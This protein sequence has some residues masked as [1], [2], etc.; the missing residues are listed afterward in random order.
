M[1]ISCKHEE[2]DTIWEINT[3]FCGYHF[4]AYYNFWQSEQWSQINGTR[5]TVET[6]EY[7]FENILLLSLVNYFTVLSVSQT[8]CQMMGQMNWKISGRKWLWPIW[9]TILA[10]ALRDYGNPWKTSVRI[11]G[12]PDKIWTKIPPPN[13]SLP[14]LPIYQP[15]QQHY[16]TKGLILNNKLKKWTSSFENL[17][18]LAPTFSRQS[19]H[20]WQWGCQPYA[21]NT[22]YLQEDS[23]YSFLLEAELT[24]RP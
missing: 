24:P 5:Q 10:F 1:E 13:I 9:G 21:Q 3:D 20:R 6:D 22:L 17:W 18:T 16:I 2:G 7:K 14:V 12:V 15:V 19:A 4:V 8:W 23:W 11:T